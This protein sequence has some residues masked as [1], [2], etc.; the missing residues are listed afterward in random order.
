M[1]RSAFA[2]A[3]AH[4]LR[5]LVALVIIKM[6]A[7]QLGP[8]GLAELGNLMNAITVI[9]VFAGGGIVTG[10]AKKVAEFNHRPHHMTRVIGSAFYYGLAFS[11]AIMAIGVVAAIPISRFLFGTTEYAWLSPC[12]GFAQFLC[13][14]GMATIA[15]ANGLRRSDL[16]A[17]ITITGY[18]SALPPAFILIYLFGLPGAALA[19]ALSISCVAL[20]ALVVIIKSP[21]TRNIRL[22]INRTDALMFFRFSLMALA[23]AV[24]YPATEVLIRTNIISAMG[25]VDAGYWQAMT[26]LSGAYLGFFTMYLMATCMPTVSSL[27]HRQDVV[28]FTYSTIV[29]LGGSFLIAA[30]LIYVFRNYIILILFSRSFIPMEELFIW[31]LVGDF[32][33]ISAYVIGIIGVAKAATKIYIIAELTQCLMYGGLAALIIHNGGNVVN[34][35]QAYALSYFL[36]FCISFLALQIYRATAK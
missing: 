1:G 10:I 8:S 14:I 31:Q 22:R 9:S 17:I 34:I 28:K 27:P 29:R 2:A 6:I 26:R 35:M 20:P 12:L 23:S 25:T 24:L 19:L 36:Y 32:F 4:G 15:I 30:I 13:F 18:L 21:I 33:R 16:F 3:T 7:L 11:V 5:M